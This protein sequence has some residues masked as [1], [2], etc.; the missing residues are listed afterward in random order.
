[1]DSGTPSIPTRATDQATSIADVDEAVARV[2]G[3][4][5][6]WAIAPLAMRIDLLERAM[7][8]TLEVARDWVT[9]AQVAKGISRGQRSASED[10]FSGPG[11]VARNLR[12]LRDT[13]EDIQTVGSPQ[14]AS[15]TTR[16][17]GRTVVRAYP[18]DP[19]D[20]LFLPGFTGDIVMQDGVTPDD[21]RDRMGEFLRPG[22]P[23]HGGEVAVVLGAG[24]VSSIPPMDVLTQLFQHGRTVVLKMNPVNEVLTPHIERALAVFIDHDLLR[25]V[26][27]GATVGAHLTS[28]DDVDAIHVTG[29]DK[30][31]DAIVYGTGKKGAERKARDTPILDKEFTSE[32]GNVSPVIVVP[33]PWSSDDIAFH[34]TNIASMV[35]N[36]AGFNCIAARVVVTHAQW[37]RRRALLDA[38]RDSLDDAEDRVAYYPGAA[39]RWESFV[40]AH[41][42]AEQFGGDLAGSLPFTLIPDLDATN[43]DD[44]AFTTEA[45]CGVFG[46]VGLDAPRSVPDYVD[47]AVDFVNGTLWGTLSASIIVHPRSLEDPQ[48]AAAVDRAIDNLE[49]GSVVLNHW[50]GLTYG[51]VSLPWGGAPDQARNDIQSGRGFVHNTYLVPDDLID[52]A[53]L[54]GPF[55]MPTTPAL[56]HTNQRGEDI[57][58]ALAEF[59]ATRSMAILPRLTWASLRG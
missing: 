17:D 18:S 22:G 40:A 29:S 6:G 23:N 39:R 28:H 3:A 2:R 8:D 34:G 21:V 45:F 27:G 57:A 55:R 1:M 50:S 59:E 31:H 24:N 15:V 41:P 52:K 5:P 35:V 51:T 4:A 32:L 43:T 25:V 44:I 49:Y 56:S 38:V 48:I 36:N 37:N 14:P 47:Q 54:R 58:K 12:L 42:E 19:M 30:T 16:E 7:A 33:G 10:W 26:R 46:E 20:Q 13:L 9:T 53:V 11:M